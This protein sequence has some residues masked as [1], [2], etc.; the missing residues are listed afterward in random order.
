MESLSFCFFIIFTIT[1]ANAQIMITNCTELQMMQTGNASSPV[2]YI[3][4]NDIDCSTTVNFIPIGTLS[5]P[6]F[7]EIDGQGH[8]I[9][10]LKINTSLYAGIIEYAGNCNISN[11]VL[12]NCSISSSSYS[13]YSSSTGG[14]IANSNSGTTTIITITNCSLQSCSISSISNSTNPPSYSGGLIGNPNTAKIVITN[15]SVQNC[16]ITSSST[17]FCSSYSGG[18]IGSVHHSISV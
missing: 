7:G 1:F 11:I 12:K 18:L 14:L 8:S 17:S 15:C 2:N 10:N 4:A 3:L 6:F 13:P 16:S 5:N 9:Y